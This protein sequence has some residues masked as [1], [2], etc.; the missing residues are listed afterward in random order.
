[1][2]TII[3]SGS[4]LVLTIAL[5]CMTYEV[6]RH[7]KAMGYLTSIAESMNNLLIEYKRE[8]GKQALRIT[9]LEE[10]VTNLESKQSQ[11]AKE[12]KKLRNSA[13]I[14]EKDND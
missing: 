14:L 8:I 3:I 5:I 12:I 2:V 7:E 1:M 10:R 6:N 9:C 4:V 11:M 13:V